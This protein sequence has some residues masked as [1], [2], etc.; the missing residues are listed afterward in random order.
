MWP[1]N[2]D[3]I[4]EKVQPYITNRSRRKPICAGERLAITL[5]YVHI[6]WV[7]TFLAST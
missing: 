1:E 4:L 7:R 5:R 3:E 6:Y 2:F